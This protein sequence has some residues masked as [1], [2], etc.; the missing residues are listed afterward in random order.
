[1]YLRQ[2]LLILEKVAY[3][4]TKSIPK[5]KIIDDVFLNN[6]NYCLK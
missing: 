2:Y 4:Q 1:M 3:K 5:L 6:I